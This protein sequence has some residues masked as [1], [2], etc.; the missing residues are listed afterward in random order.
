MVFKAMN[1][2]FFPWL[3]K[4]NNRTGRLR[5]KVDEDR[6]KEMKKTILSGEQIE[7]SDPAEAKHLCLF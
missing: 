1:Q 6:F 3:F 5:I 7:L 2:S 4:L